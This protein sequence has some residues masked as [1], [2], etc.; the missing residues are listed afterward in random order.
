MPRS[1]V[2]SQVGGRNVEGGGAQPLDGGQKPPDATPPENEEEDE[3]TDDEDR[4][5][6][7]W[8]KWQKLNQQVSLKKVFRERA[9]ERER[10]RAGER[11]RHLLQV[12]RDVP[13]IDAAYLAMDTEEGVEV[14]W[15]EV[16]YSHRRMVKGSRVSWSVCL[17][18]C[19]SLSKNK[20]RRD[21]HNS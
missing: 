14:V 1:P 18:V 11:E 6:E 2:S 13:G 20:T 3:D 21:S 10:E 15:N 19:L 7:E 12:P 17:S 9:L 16:R 5:L 8:S 4:V